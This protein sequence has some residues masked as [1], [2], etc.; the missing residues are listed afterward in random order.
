MIRRPPRSTLFPYTTLFRSPSNT[1]KSSRVRSATDCPRASRAATFSLIK[2]ADG[3]RRSSSWP[4]GR[5]RASHAVPAAARRPASAHLDIPDCRLIH[6]Q[7]VCRRLF[8]T[9]DEVLGQWSLHGSGG[10]MGQRA[11]G[12]KA[13]SMGIYDDR[14]RLMVETTFNSDVGDSW[15][16][17]D[18]PSY[19]EKFSAL[20]IRLGV[21]FV[22][23]SMTH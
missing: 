14:N 16:C 22:V 4:L 6:D 2:G 20:G 11:A 18:S 23:Y 7:L 19:P 17:A 15:E 5:A 13:H 8:D 10:W 1:W 9:I 12:T 21:N 3:G